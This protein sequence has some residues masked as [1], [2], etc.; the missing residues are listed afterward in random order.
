[1]KA[2]LGVCLGVLITL[3]VQVPFA[4]ADEETEY[5]RYSEFISLVETGQIRSVTLDRHSRLKGIQ[6]MSGEERPFH[7][8]ADTGSFDD[9]L[10]IRLLREN[11]VGRMEVKYA[12]SQAEGASRKWSTSCGP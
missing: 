2:I 11:N 12:L 7:S 4:G 9:P 10:L 5:L 8:F 1:M 6:V 3:S